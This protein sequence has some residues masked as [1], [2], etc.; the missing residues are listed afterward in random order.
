MVASSVEWYLDALTFIAPSTP[1]EGRMKP[2]QKGCPFD[3]GPCKS[4]QQRV[5]V[6]IVPITSTLSKETFASIVSHVGETQDEID[7]IEFTGSE[8]TIHHELPTFLTMSREAGIRH[9]TLSTDG[10]TSLTE[11]DATMLADYDARVALTLDAFDETTTLAVVELLEKHGVTITLRPAVALALTESDMLPLA[12][13]F[14]T[15]PNIC[16]LELHTLTKLSAMNE[17]AP[18][19]RTTT[20]DLHRVIGAATSGKIAWTDFVPSPLAHPHC[21][22]ICYLLALDDGGYVPYTRFMSRALLF[23]LLGDS[24]Y[25]RPHEKTEEA[26]L[27]AIDALSESAEHLP[28]AASVVRTLKRLINEMFPPGA[29][30]PLA[31][32]EK[33]AD[34]AIKAIYIHSHMDVES[35]DVSRVMKCSVGVPEADGTNIPLCAYN[36]V[37]RDTD[38]RA[39]EPAALDPTAGVASAARR[40]VARS[41]PI[42]R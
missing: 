19:A 33:I 15:K 4:H 14:L 10:L 1:P 3:C 2:I 27:R 26:F 17:G 28:Q 23:E 29:V 42:V 6:P 18:P 20:P 39:A 22:S 12:Q 40:S 11:D 24:I 8:P 13:L 30:V 36:V 32:R 35:F 25:I 21:Y 16:S 7:S 34:R 31:R 5:F 9:V 37:Y 38:A 41:L